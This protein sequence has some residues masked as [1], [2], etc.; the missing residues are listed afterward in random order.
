MRA[1]FSGGVERRTLLPLPLTLHKW[2]LQKWRS[3]YTKKIVFNNQSLCDLAPEIDPIIATTVDS[4][5][6][7]QVKNN[8][9]THG[10]HLLRV[11]YVT[12]WTNYL[13]CIISFNSHNNLMKQVHYCTHKKLKLREVRHLFKIAQLTNG[14]ALMSRLLSNTNYVISMNSWTKAKKDLKVWMA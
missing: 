6:I 9:N 3:G 2:L 11:Y 10:Y 5:E 4:L 8:S 13:E 12:Q 7:D 14:R 1:I